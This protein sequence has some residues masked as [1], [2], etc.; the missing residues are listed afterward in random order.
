MV[1]GKWSYISFVF[2]L[3]FFFV[4][5]YVFVSKRH[6]GSGRISAHHPPKSPNLPMSSATPSCHYKDFIFSMIAKQKLQKNKKMGSTHWLKE[7]LS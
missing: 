5:D 2:V 3:F 7:K 6:W 1:L 4:V